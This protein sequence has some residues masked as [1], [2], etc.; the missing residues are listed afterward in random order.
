MQHDRRE[1]IVK[2]SRDITAQSK[3]AIFALQ[4]VSSA[5]R[6]QAL[7][8]ADERFADIRKLFDAVAPE[9]EGENFFR[10]A[11]ATCYHQRTA[12]ADL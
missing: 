11:L 8:D 1:R 12:L 10:S 2:I 3:K 9:L 7:H 5:G 4:R 6:T